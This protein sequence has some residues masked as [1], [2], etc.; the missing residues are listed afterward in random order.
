MKRSFLTGFCLFTGVFLFFAPSADA[1]EF[2]ARAFYWFTSV[3]SD[4]RVDLGGIAGTEVNLKNDLG[5]GWEGVPSVEAYAGLGRHH[6]SLT[7]TQG[8]YSGSTTLGKPIKFLGQQYAAHALLDSDFRIR[9][10]DVEY[11]YDLLNFENILAGFSIGVIGKLKY[12]D[13]D[14]ELA[15]STPR[16]AHDLKESFS[17]PL[18]MA[19]VGVHVGLLLNILE[20]RA[21]VTGGYSSGTAIYDASADLSVTPFPFVDIHAGYKIMKLPVSGIGGDDTDAEF[22]GPFVGLTVGF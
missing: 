7:Y 19:G 9:M 15:S 4:L 2:G 5:M 21:K 13:G 14:I 6:V 8:D 11:Q 22:S 10:L 17:D 12:I 16:S 1:L 18:P 20:A 3:R